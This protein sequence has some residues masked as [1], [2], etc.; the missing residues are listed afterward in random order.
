MNP[1]KW[2]TTGTRIKGDVFPSAL[3][4]LRDLEDPKAIHDS[5]IPQAAL[6]H[7]SDCLETNMVASASGKHSVAIGLLRSC[8]EAITLVDIG[9]QSND[10]RLSRIHQWN[11]RTSTAGALRKDL[12]RDIWPRYG[13]GLWDEPWTDYFGNLAR[14]LHPYA[15][16]SPDLMGWQMALVTM[17][18]PKRQGFAVLGPSTYDPLKATRITLLHTLILWTVGR[19]VV[20]NST[21]PAPQLS[22]TLEQL[23]CEIGSS[24]LLFREGDWG[25]EL[26][27]HVWFQEGVDWRV[28]A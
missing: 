21:S 24:G 12:Q 11:A 1:P 27:P 10:Y 19:F 2:F 5:I 14:A 6:F 4:R 15:H 8:L 23:R 28:Q 26:M 16:Y 20:L 3:E 13:T 22:A 7:L 9:L 25:V 17:D 18:D